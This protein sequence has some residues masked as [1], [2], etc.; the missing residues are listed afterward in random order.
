M[1]D[2]DLFGLEPQNAALGPELEAAFARVLASGSFILGAEVEALEREVAAFLGAEHAVGVSSGSDAL[3]CALLALGCGPGDE[4]V[5]PAFSFFATPEAICRVGAKPRFVDVELDA[6]G[7]DLGGVEAALGPRT[8]A[9]LPVHL[10]GCPVDLDGIERLAARA[11]IP[12]IEDAAQAFGASFAGRRAGTW[13]TAG[14]FSFFPTKP[15]G[16]FGDGGMIVTSDSQIAARCR[17]LRAHGAAGKHQ[18][19]EIG[20]NYRLDALQAALLRVKLRH[21][22]RWRAARAAHAE[23]YAQGLADVAEIVVPRLP[24][25]AVSAHALFTV[26]VQG[27][28]RDALARALL[29]RGIHTAV[30]YPRPLHLQPALAGY[31]Y[32]AGDFPQAELACE[33]VLSLPLSAALSEADRAR[34]IEAIRE[35][36]R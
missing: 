17:S 14:C 22:E 29:A 11:G 9:L 15:L 10:Y 13:G 8:R 5:L 31:G 21:V 4:V 28:E 26:R 6:F 7:M 18:H 1:A 25:A 23:A 19:G 34:V 35:H 30:Y 20:G 24:S 33:Q 27:G 32:R 16:G 36:F 12:V 3:V 2:I